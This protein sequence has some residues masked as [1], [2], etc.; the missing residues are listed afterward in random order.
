MSEPD[1]RSSNR[2]AVTSG[3]RTA[4]AVKKTHDDEPKR[5]TF[6]VRYPREEGADLV[7]ATKEDL[8]K[9]PTPSSNEEKATVSARRITIRVRLRTFTGLIFRE[10]NFH[11]TR[12]RTASRMRSVTFERCDFIRTFMGTT[13]FHRVRFRDC[14]FRNCDFSN[15]EFYECVFERCSFNNCS[16]ESAIFTK[17]EV[18]ATEFLGGISFPQ[19]NLTGYS[20]EY[21]ARL[22]RLWMEIRLRLAEQVFRSN[23]EINHSEYL[24]RALFELKRA[25][26]CYRY[27][28]WRHESAVPTAQRRSVVK[29][30]TSNLAGSVRLF[31]S[32]VN[33]TLTRGGT[34]LQNLF[35]ILL[36]STV[37]YPFLLASTDVAFNDA[38]ISLASDSASTFLLSYLKFF[39]ASV[40][41]ILGFGFTSFKAESIGGMT[42]TVVGATFGIF[43]YA[44]LIPV[45]IRKI[46]R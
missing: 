8:S 44:L 18:D 37:L 30:V 28:L 20:A 25:Q 2:V 21:T 9:L 36:L 39:L 16:A 42:V 17:S 15:S 35:S 43:W 12:G 34:S 6:G 45:I 38:R 26:L 13:V 33:I 41:L 46:Y 4:S 29:S 27:D 31:L 19:Y 7:F 14:T 5:A 1:E 40:S 24:D 11:N 10:C 3:T 23:G 22:H 32:W